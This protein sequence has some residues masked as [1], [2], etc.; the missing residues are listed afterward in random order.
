M[1]PVSQGEL[2]RDV[3]CGG[4]TE[5]SG[6]G[7][8]KRTACVANG[9]RK[10]LRNKGAERPVGNAHQR[11]SNAHHEECATETRCEERLESETERRD[12]D[13]NDDHD[14]AATELGHPRRN[15]NGDCKEECGQKLKCEKAGIG[16]VQRLGAPRKREYHHQVEQHKSRET[17]ENARE[18]LARIATKDV[19]QG[20]LDPFGAADRLGEDRCFCK[21]ETNIESK[22]DEQSGGKEGKARAEGEKL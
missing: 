1:K 6:G 21:G 20:E 10:E 19:E 13:G 4:S 2:C 14:A 3:R 18:E 11:K 15:R 9:C 8:S 5:N 22:Q 12:G 7:E 16:I 17:D